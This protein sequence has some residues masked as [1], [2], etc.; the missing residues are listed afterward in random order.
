MKNLTD[1]VAIVTGASRG[2]GRAIA[3]R[4]GRDGAKVVVNYMGSGD[5]AQ[6]VVASIEAVSGQAVAVQAN[7]SQVTDIRRLFQE[8]VDRFGQLDI[9][10]NNAGIVGK[11]VGTGTPVA[12][13]TEEEFDAV[14]ALNVRGV[15]FALQEAARRM[16]EG[17]RIVNISSSLTVHSQAGTAI[18]AASKGAENLFTQ[19]LAKELGGRGITV[20]SVMPGPTS[21]GSFD[22][23]PPQIKKVA[24][25]SSPFG[26]TGHASDIADIVAFVVSE[27]ARW[28]TGQNILANGG[29]SF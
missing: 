3:E 4:L 15:L 8:T 16:K 27:E 24:A 7:M 5:K 22:M 18:Y 20:N 28:I 10:V 12:E 9:L 11:R 13:V 26:R 1:K 14:F 17:G 23:V 29:A 25:E 21:P 6:E 2:I 19:V